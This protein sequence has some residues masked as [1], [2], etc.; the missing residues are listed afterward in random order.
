[1]SQFTRFTV[2]AAFVVGFVFWSLIA[3]VAHPHVW[4]DVRSEIVFDDAGLVSEIQHHWTFDEAFSAWTIQGL[5]V[6]GDDKVSPDEMIELAAQN[7]VGLGEFDF[8]T[9]AGEGTFNVSFLPG[10]SPHMSYDDG[11][12]TLNF[13]LV[14]SVPFAIRSALELEVTDAEYYIDLQ[15]ISDQATTLVNAPAG[16]AV[17]S[18][19]PNE[20]EP[21]LADQLAFI[22]PDVLVL[23]EELRNALAGLK[24][25]AVVT[26]AADTAAGAVAQ[27]AASTPKSIKTTTPF[28]APPVER[29][30]TM[31][32]SGLLGW[33][34]A[35]QKQFYGAL[36]DALS[37]FKQDT[38]AFW[39]LGGLSFLYGVFHAAGPGHGKVVISSYVL[40]GERD[41][42]RGIMLSI[43]AAMM[44]SVTA[45]VF[46]LIAVGLLNMTS[47]A[48][49]G[50]AVSIER[51]S[52]AMV[53]A[54]G[55]WL[56]IRNVFG[57]GHNHG[58]SH[59]HDHHHDGEHNHNHNHDHGHDEHCCH[60]VAPTPTKNWREVAGVVLAVGLRPCSGA[61]VV[62]VFAFSQNVLAAG[63]AA[64]FLMGIGTAITV[65]VLA[66]LA[67]G[68]KTLALSFSEKTE[69]G[70][71]INIVKMLE[72]GG[73]IVLL[74]FGLILLSASLWG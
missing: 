10:P 7:M 72:I 60:A 21:E 70:L 22:G 31:P 5:D 40:A 52:Y 48:M 6:N 46:V 39:I 47:I 11:R 33:V 13:S 55:A 64:V 18:Y 62:L 17:T 8:Y 1:M 28:A 34:N 2:R 41:A 30:L 20:L 65:S 50:V 42:R 63:I 51:W 35:K 71:A 54:L 3:A 45:I 25:L 37:A 26:C 38:N 68:A 66:S 9:F 4:V 14:P 73:A 56:L 57:L 16:C 43:A 59:S 61:L 69:S 29:G 36:S 12:T 19:P 58:H 27:V 32:K 74:G 24:N 44:Q 67:L 23:P 15:F 49:S 53:V